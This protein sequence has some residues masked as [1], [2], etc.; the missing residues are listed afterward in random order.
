[1][2]I[3]GEGQ[4]WKHTPSPKRD[5]FKFQT[6]TLMLCC[7]FSFLFLFKKQF[8][9][10]AFYFYFLATPTAR[11]NFQARDQTH[12]TGVTRAIAVTMPGP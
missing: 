10:L 2:R 8:P 3:T 12:A 9:G 4:G 7:R 11:A 5:S 1:M 6:G